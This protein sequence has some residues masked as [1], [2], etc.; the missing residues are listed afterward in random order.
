MMIYIL[1][2]NMFYSFV[3]LRLT[4]K[5]RSECYVFVQFYVHSPVCLKDRVLH[6]SGNLPYLELMYC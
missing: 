6:H 5:V 4:V 3:P 2:F 1:T